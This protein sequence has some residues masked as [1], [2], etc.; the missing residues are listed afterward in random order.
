[1][2]QH[3]RLTIAAP[4]ALLAAAPATADRASNLAAGRAA[5]ITAAERQQGTNAN[6]GIV[7]SF[8]GA[9]SGP[10]AAYVERIGRR[11]ALQSGLASD[12]GAFD[13]TLLNSPV[14]NAFA[15]PGGY[16]YVTRQIVALMNDEAELAAVLGH[17]VAHVAARHSERRQAVDQ[18]NNLLGALG[19]VLVGAVVG[20]DGIGDLLGRGIGAGAQLATLGYSRGQETQSDDLGIHYLARAGYDPAALSTML[21]SLAAQASLDQR[22][23]GD[24]RTPPAWASTHPDPGVRVRRAADQAARL[25][26]TGP[27]NR[28]AFLA[29]IDGMLYGDDRTQGVI[30]GRR[31]LLPTA[32]IAFT[33]PQGY[34]LVNGAA[35]VTISGPGAQAQFSTARY[36]GDIDTYVRRV[37]A[38]LSRGTPAP[39]VTVQVAMI[40]GMPAARATMRVT[41]GQTAVDTTV[42]A[43]A[44]SGTQAYHFAIVAPAGQGTGALVTMVDS[45]RRM[46]ATEASAVRA[47]YVRIVAVRDGDTVAGLAGRMAFDDARLERFLVL[48]RLSP[49]ATLRA[50]DKVKIVTF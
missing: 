9:V 48:N 31:F 45:F 46:T 25:G 10:Q 22:L 36:N 24:A 27:R 7:A 42:V 34:T 16:V 23:A 14:N 5:P 15:V 21:E 19:R 3:L 37:S 40:G 12:S 41:S 38:S 8:G 1:M 30:D 18:R 32:R 20:N 29:A 44:V 13:V 6:A 17:E 35:A 11:I 50:G 43:Y 26:T 4:L 49:N 39:P 28:E 33:V 47:R 2:P